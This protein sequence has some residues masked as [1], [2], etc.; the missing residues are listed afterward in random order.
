M[1]KKKQGITL[2]ELIIAMAILSIIG[3]AIV[4]LSS[5]IVRSYSAVNYKTTSRDMATI[6][7]Q[8]IRDEIITA[9]QVNIAT[10]L[11]NTAPAGTYQIYVSNDGNVMHKNGPDAATTVLSAAGNNMGSGKWTME[12]KFRQI[13]IDSSV[14]PPISTAAIEIEVL[15]KDPGG[16]DHSFTTQVFLPNVSID[17]T[18]NTVIGASEGG[19][20][21]FTQKDFS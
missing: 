4:G 10:S 21:S 11:N 9:N 13:I 6:T 16:K 5:S 14:T 7:M 2:I 15:V 19:Y 18:E 12:V 1:I 3:V 20:L 17:T 8:T